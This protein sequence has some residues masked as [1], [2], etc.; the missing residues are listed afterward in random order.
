MLKVLCTASGEDGIEAEI[1]SASLDSSVLG[2]NLS[3]CNLFS[4]VPPVSSVIRPGSDSDMSGQAHCSART[5]SAS[6]SLPE[7][8]NSEMLTREAEASSVPSSGWPQ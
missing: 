4:F 6:Q 1:H 2:L 3:S 7:G 8:D 5:L